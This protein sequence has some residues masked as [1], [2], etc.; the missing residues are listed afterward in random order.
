MPSVFSLT[1]VSKFF[2]LPPPP[3]IL[4]MFCTCT[5][6]TQHLTQFVMTP[7]GKKADPN[8]GPNTRGSGKRP[9]N[10]TDSSPPRNSRHHTGDGSIADECDGLGR[11]LR[12]K[13]PTEK[14]KANA[15]HASISVA[16][17]RTVVDLTVASKKPTEKAKANATH[18]SIS[19]ATARTVVD[20]TVTSTAGSADTAV[21]AAGAS[22]TSNVSS[23]GVSCPRRSKKPTEKAIANAT[24]ASISAA[25]SAS[26]IDVHSGLKT[27]KKAMLTMAVDTGTPATNSDQTTAMQQML[28]LA[29]Y[30]L[31]HSNSDLDNKDHANAII[32]VSLFM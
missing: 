5:T 22:T 15:T 28:D 26:V 31:S 12:L 29:Y 11:S 20:P 19:V 2:L 32:N 18:A 25:A 4:S 6:H 16:T 24:H 23:D 7:R 3:L 10:T 1:N 30:L 9:S 27:T 13:K 17:A 14:A 8:N 21:S